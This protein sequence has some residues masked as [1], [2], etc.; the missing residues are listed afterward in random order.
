MGMSVQKKFLCGFAS[1]VLFIGLVGFFI[2]FFARPSSD[3]ESCSGGKNG[4]EETSGMLGYEKEVLSQVLEQ[5]I[6]YY[7]EWVSFYTN[8]LNTTI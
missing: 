5:R 8:M 6:R 7:L 2:G 1:F 4:N 3:S